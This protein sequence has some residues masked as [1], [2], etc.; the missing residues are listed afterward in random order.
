VSAPVTTLARALPPD[1][2]DDAIQL[3]DERGVAKLAL[4][5]EE[6]ESIT[7]AATSAPL[8]TKADEG[9]AAE[10]LSRGV[11]AL[12]ELDTLRRAH[13]DPINAQVKATNGIFKRITDP[14]EALV[15]KGGRLERLILAFR[16]QERARIERERQEAERKQREAAEREAAALRK[17]EAAKSEAARQRALREAEAASQAQTQ[18]A[19]EVP[20]AMTRGVRTDSGSVTQRERW[21]LQGIHDLGAVPPEYW[22]QA[23]VV[24]ALKKVLQKA[25]DGG[26]RAIPGCSIGL[27]ES[28]TRRTG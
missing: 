5:V 28:L 19:I 10:L 9:K 21:V 17:A 20:Q 15:G 25:I 24:E 27:E 1:A 13:V 2:V 16:T 6:I 8:A 18:A 12:K 26:V 7:Q 4:F 11:I 22:D 23:P 14:L 3:L